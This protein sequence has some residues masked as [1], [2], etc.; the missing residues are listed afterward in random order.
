MWNSQITKPIEISY[1]ERKLYID[2]SIENTCCDPF[3]N[4]SFVNEGRESGRCNTCMELPVVEAR[5]D[6]F[7]QG[8]IELKIGLQFDRVKMNQLNYP[9]TW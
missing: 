5:W 1:E 8:R 2:Y 9:C 3:S 4:V 6:L 7:P